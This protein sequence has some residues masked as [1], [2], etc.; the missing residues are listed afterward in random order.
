MKLEKIRIIH[1]V[2]ETIASRDWG[3]AINYAI[4]KNLLKLRPLIKGFNEENMIRINTLCKKNE[5]GG[6][7]ILNGQYDFGE[8]SKVAEEKYEEILQTEV[9][10][11][12]YTVCRSAE[13]DKLPAAVQA[14]LLG[15]I[16]I[17]N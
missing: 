14:E 13:T 3:A 8:N 4:A 10:F 5:K 17:E 15:I 6:L 7:I 9:S 11:E 1:Q 16:I 12:P 2:L